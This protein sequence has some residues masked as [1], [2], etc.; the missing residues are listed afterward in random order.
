MPVK[1]NNFT[2]QAKATTKAAPPKKNGKGDNTYNEEMS[3]D[4][5]ID[6]CVE[7]VMDLINQKFQ[8]KLD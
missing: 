8:D 4:E 3:Q 7:K 1:I 2:I 6:T 5:L